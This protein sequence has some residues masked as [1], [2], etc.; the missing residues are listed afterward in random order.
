M[1]A[2]STSWLLWRCVKESFSFTL[3]IGAIFLVI[4]FKSKMWL[5]TCTSSHVSSAFCLDWI[6][7]TCHKLPISSS[8][9]SELFGKDTDV[10]FQGWGDIST[11]CGH[12]L[13]S[14]S[15]GVRESKN[16]TVPDTDSPRLNSLSSVIIEWKFLTLDYLVPWYKNDAVDLG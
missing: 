14:S 16:I 13:N 1:C 15:V 7:L 11:M 3:F 8:N 6:E 2:V 5:L 4:V 12:V 10:S 9:D